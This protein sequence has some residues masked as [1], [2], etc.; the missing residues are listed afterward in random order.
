MTSSQINRSIIPPKAESQL[1]LS[2]TGSECPAP[3]DLLQRSSG[4]ARA[5]SSHFSPTSDDATRPG[6]VGPDP[7]RASGVKCSQNSTAGPQLIT[8][9]SGPSVFDPT[10][11]YSTEQVVLFWQPPSCFSRWSPS[12]FVVDDVSCSCAEQFMMAEKAR[13]FQ[14][15]RTEELV[16][17]SPDPSAHKRIGGGV[18]NFDNAVWNRVGTAFAKT[19]SLLEILP[20]FHRTRP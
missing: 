20:S 12:S 7:S 9:C 5:P 8:D 1:S 6:P 11:G 18:C 15:H 10:L 17:S 3:L 19:Q 4:A 13:L 14:D 16:M 2:R